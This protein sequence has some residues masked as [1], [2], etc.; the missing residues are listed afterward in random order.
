MQRQHLIPHHPKQ[1]RGEQRR[2]GMRG[3]PGPGA[4]Q[5][6]PCVDGRHLAYQS[7]ASGPPL[8]LAISTLTGA[9]PSALSVTEKVLAA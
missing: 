7:A 3:F 6:P 5:V 4:A 9:K 2:T 8:S 1:T